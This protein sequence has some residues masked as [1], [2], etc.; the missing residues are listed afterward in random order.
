MN[1]K[2]WYKDVFVPWQYAFKKD[3]PI[4][5]SSHLNFFIMFETQVME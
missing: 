4:E 1:K 5:N 3:F 2:G